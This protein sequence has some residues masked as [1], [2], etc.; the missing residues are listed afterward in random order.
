MYNRVEFDNRKAANRIKDEAVARDYRPG[1]ASFATPSSS[2]GGTA[3]VSPSLTGDF[4]Y[5]DEN[6][7]TVRPFMLDVDQ[8]DDPT[9]RLT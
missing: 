5:P 9:A 3:S 4:T 6:G 8:M 7:N 2:P 1:D